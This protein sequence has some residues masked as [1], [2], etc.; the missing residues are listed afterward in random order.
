M[1]EQR[2][3]PNFLS[4]S[5]SRRRVLRGLVVAAAA[6][7]LAAACAPQQAPAK[8]AESKP[9]E[10]AKP[11]APAAAAPTAGAAAKTDAKPA[12]AAKPAAA[13]GQPKTGGSLKVAILG[14]P[15]ALDIMFTTATVTRNTAWH[16]FETLYANNSK[17]EPQPFLAEKGEV[18]GDARTWT[19]NLRKG[20]P[21]HNGKEM[22]ADDVVASLKRWGT[23]GVRGQVIFKRIDTVT[24]KDDYTVVMNFKEPTGAT[25][26]SFLAEGSSFIMPAEIAEKFPKDKLSEY[27][28]TGPFQFV[29]HQPDR[30]VRMK[31]FDKYVP[32]DKP[33]D[34]ASG[35]RVAYVDELNFIP[36]PEGTV[37]A[38][39]VGTGEYHFADDLNPDQVDSVR[40]QSNV[41]P[42][43]VMPYYWLVYH[44]NKKEGLFAG[45][46]GL[47]LRQAV[48]ASLSMEPLAKA[49]VG[50][51]E[52]WRLGPDISAK[53][54]AWHNAQ[55]G[56]DVYNKP[57]PDK[58]KALMKEAGY[59]GTPI[60]WMSTKE[61]FYNY[62]SSLP[63]K[64][65]LEANGFKVDLQIM[66]WATLVKRRSD[67]KEYDIFVTGHESFNHPILQPYLSSSWPGF[68]EN[69]ERDQITATMFTEPDP[70]KVV[71]AVRK[72]QELQWREVPCIKVCEYGKL[73]SASKKIGYEPKTDAFF[74]NV[75][76]S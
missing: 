49:G 48:L 39:G 58:A 3:S 18:S 53:E 2:L 37:R 40:G 1:D 22:K 47:K 72:L 51:Q 21:F 15:P 62:N 71:D 42:V 67:P 5:L 44:F 38:D 36:V 46:N 55:A 54:V 6:L 75:G 73:Q 41:T 7:P 52:F 25:L 34:F 60:R 57:N 74:W 24:A 19:F 68:W 28:G 16:M 17:M 33:A 8:P 27:V 32:L 23:M 63:A 70:A 50:P 76:L 4:R 65:Q 12:E 35:K 14:E 56:A 29:E 69:A 26:L 11:A 64:Q 59:D 30:F 13:A 31:R 45:P 10:P 61:Y 43:I 20:V 9:A 66:D